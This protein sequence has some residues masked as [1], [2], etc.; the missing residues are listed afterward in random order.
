[1]IFTFIIKIRLIASS[2][3][4]EFKSSTWLKKWWIELKKIWKSVELSWEVKFKHLSW[5]EKLDSTTQFE[6]LIQ[7]DKILDKCK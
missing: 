1:M 6:N 7:L 5:I 3:V 4:L 2:Q